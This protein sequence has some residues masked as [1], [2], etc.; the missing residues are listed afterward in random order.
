MSLGTV[1]DVEV[2]A[3]PGKW[4]SIFGD[5]IMGYVDRE[6]A[7]REIEKRKAKGEKARVVEV[8][9]RVTHLA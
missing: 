1:Y 2:E 4:I 5:G 7:K 3:T 9:R 8:M 6:A